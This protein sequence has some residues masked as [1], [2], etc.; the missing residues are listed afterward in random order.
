MPCVI[1]THPLYSFKKPVGLKLP[2]C[3]VLDNFNILGKFITN[4]CHEL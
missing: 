1:I 4:Y 3:F 2:Q